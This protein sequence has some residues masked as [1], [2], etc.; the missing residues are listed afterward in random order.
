MVITQ[1]QM[2][3]PLLQAYPAFTPQWEAFLEE[4]GEEKELPL[5]LLFGDLSRDIE[6]L[7]QANHFATLKDIFAV[8]ELWHVEGDAYVK[9]AATIGVLES[10]QNTNIITAFNPDQF[11]EFLGPVSKTFWF[12]VEGFWDKGELITED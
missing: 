12:K 1:S 8:I 7:Y 11:V 4:W 9:E 6:N 2:F 3:T 10:L 5:Y